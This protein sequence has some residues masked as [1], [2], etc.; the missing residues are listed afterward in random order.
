LKVLSHRLFERPDD[1]AAL[2]P[3]SLTVPFS[4]ADLADAIAKPRRLAQQMTYC[5]RKMGV[6]K[7]AGKR[8]RAVLYSRASI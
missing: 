1:F 2:L 6:L 7:P 8:G 4:T 3:G 5:M